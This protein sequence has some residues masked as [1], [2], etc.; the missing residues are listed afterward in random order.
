M[1]SFFPLGADAEKQ[2]DAAS[3]LLGLCCDAVVELDSDFCLLSHSKALA[4]LLLRSNNL[5]GSC[6]FDLLCGTDRERAM[7]HL[8][9]FGGQ[10]THPE[11]HCLIYFQ[12]QVTAMIILRHIHHNDHFHLLDILSG[13]KLQKASCILVSFD[14]V[15]GLFDFV[16]RRS[17]TS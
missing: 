17:G 12:S 11:F 2:F 4:A 7:E 9:N 1:A 10:G 16:Y 15:D 13:R 14:T 5:A 8:R 6:F 3:T